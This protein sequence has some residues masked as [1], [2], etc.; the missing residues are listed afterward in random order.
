ML[1][2]SME[3]VQTFL[4]FGALWIHDQNPKRPH[5]LLTSGLHS[6]GF[7]NFGVFTESP[8]LVEQAASDLL[9]KLRSEDARGFT[10][11]RVARV[12]GPAMGAITLAHE[13]ARQIG[14]WR[15]GSCKTAYAEKTDGGVMTINRA[16]IIPGEIVLVCEDVTT[17]GKS[18]NATAEAVMA[19]GGNV[20]PLIATVVNRSDSN[21]AFGRK[22]VALVGGDVLHTYPY[23]TWSAEEC[24]LCKAGSEALRPKEKGNW[25]RL[26]A[27]Y[28]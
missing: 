19:S 8:K 25:A 6:A 2:T 1:K 10:M 7:W 3:W 5:A 15:S 13:L 11:H 14:R 22:I 24:P 18:G 27:S 16:G 23:G 26:N 9:E 21:E 20:L 4:G 12:V 28:S 17:S